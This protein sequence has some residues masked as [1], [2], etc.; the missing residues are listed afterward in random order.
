[1]WLLATPTAYLL[2]LATAATL[3][4]KAH[5]VRALSGID[6]WLAAWLRAVLVDLGVYLGAAA[7]LVWLERRS[8]WLRL[9]TVPA[10]VLL[11]AIGLVNAGLLAGAGEQLT[12]GAV[13]YGIDRWDDLV[14]IVGEMLAASSPVLLI[15]VPLAVLAAP[16]AVRRALDRRPGTWQR[17]LHG[18]G[19][20]RTAGLAAVLALLLTLALPDARTPELRRLEASAVAR[21]LGS[22]AVLPAGPV[23][24]SPGFTPAPLVSLPARRALG[25][26]RLPN[27]L[28][29]ILESTRWDATELAESPMG[30]VRTPHLLALAERGIV[31]TRARAALPHTTKS[32]YSI[33][34]ARLPAMQ[35]SIH[36][37]SP[38]LAVECLPGL[39]AEV[40]WRTGFFQ[41]AA[42]TFEDRPRLVH[43]LGFE[44]FEARED[45]GGERL[46]YLASDDESL[47]A[48]VL[49]WIDEPG[50]RSRPWLATVLTSAPHHPYRLSKL[51]TERAAAT[52]AAIASREDRYLRLV[53]AQDVLLGA[54]VEGLARRK[55]L[56]E[57]LVIA[58]GDH[59]EG[60]GRKGPRQHDNNYYE[61]GLHVPFVLAGPGVPAG[62][63][64]DANVS[65]VDVTPTLLGL[66]ETPV[67]DPPAEGW[68]LL[69]ASFPEDRPR[70]FGCLYTDRCEGFVLGATKVVVLPEEK[71]TYVFDLARDPRETTPRDASEA[72]QPEVQELSRVINDHR[73]PIS[74]GLSRE[75]VRLG[76]WV[77]E[78]RDTCRF[79]RS[80]RAGARR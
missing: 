64:R 62:A 41:S 4:A 10:A 11:A 68:D 72:P 6:L 58:L 63:T 36:E 54:L 73:L 35:E 22:W 31:A 8:P 32:L 20:T 2:L 45:I 66:L 47:A 30:P 25:A 14:M 79:R 60:F 67:A 69:A 44:H 59:G 12:W 61:E 80:F 27:V 56:G 48:P 40:G 51:A 15:L 39:L 76:S 26:V 16:L 7:L 46:G 49:R 33:F 78:A 71:K 70:W 75:E 55:I 34:C 57:T 21:T 37:T 23:E 74:P 19:V 77:C 42:G 13:K 24:I 38:A 18:R 65:L 3:A 43:N 29:V 9:L 1:M 52:G 28:L 5:A 53:E 50:Q 17:A